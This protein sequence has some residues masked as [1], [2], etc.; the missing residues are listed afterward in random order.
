MS[1]SDSDL[2]FESAD[3][4]AI[5]DVNVENN[6]ASP[7]KLRL[8]SVE[9]DPA[10]SLES[11]NALLCS[12]IPEEK[13][14]TDMSKETPLKLDNLQISHT[15]DTDKN[16][17]RNET[18]TENINAEIKKFESDSK[19]THVDNVDD[20]IVDTAKTETSANKNHEKQRVTLRLEKKIQ[21]KQQ[22][23][24]DNS[25][26]NDAIETSGISAKREEQKVL[27]LLK[28]FRIIKVAVVTQ[29]KC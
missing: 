11:P 14:C 13:T 28:Y 3:E 21:Q 1:E 4:D 25:V 7:E 24:K 27:Y 26:E 10:I 6:N 22:V 17:N 18:S 12:E 15:Q 20:N 9:K 2:D 29:F 16:V 8:E 23:L 5:G 19:N